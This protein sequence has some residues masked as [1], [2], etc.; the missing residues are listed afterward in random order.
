MS[1]TVEEFVSL[2]ER[3]VVYETQLDDKHLVLQIYLT[4]FEHNIEYDTRNESAAPVYVYERAGEPIAW[5]NSDDMIG[6]IKA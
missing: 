6:H 4:N 1:Y 3:N 2:N 5:Y